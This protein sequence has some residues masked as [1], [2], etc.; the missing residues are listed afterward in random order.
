MRRPP[1]IL[2]VHQGSELYGSDRV[3]LQSLEALNKHYSVTLHVPDAHAQWTPYSVI[4]GNLW[5]LRF[6]DMCR[7][8]FIQFGHFA[9]SVAFCYRTAKKHQAVYINTNRILPYI[10]LGVFMRRKFILH[11]H[12]INTGLFKYMYNPVLRLFRG[13]VIANSNATAQSLPR[14]IKPV[15]V[16]NGSQDY[17][18]APKQA[19]EDLKI[20]LP[21]RI[22]SWKGQVLALKAMDKLRNHNITLRIVGG[23]YKGQ[24]HFLEQLQQMI[25]EY[26]LHAKVELIDFN[27]DIAVHYHWADVV[28]VPSTRPEP[29]GLVAI[30]AMSAETP[31]IAANHGGLPEIVLQGETGLLFTPK[32]ENALAHAIMAYYNDRTLTAKHGQAARKRYLSYFR[33]THYAENFIRTVN[34]HVA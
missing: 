5:I 6:A 12:E 30:E 29:F 3:F 22:N 1:N 13:L 27:H 14:R 2:C 32:D 10:V 7:N 31:V 21:G 20:L 19:G 24:T 17:Y 28:L 4:S 11:V 15:V 26:H 23:V 18:I 8:P 16:H 25:G 33:H 34:S 9:K